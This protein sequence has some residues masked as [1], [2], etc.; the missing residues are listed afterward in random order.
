MTRGYAVIVGI[1]SY[2]GG[3][4]LEQ[5]VADATAMSNILSA[6]PYDFDVHLL[7]DEDAT[8]GSIKRKI[9]ACPPD[10]SLL[11]VYFS[12]HGYVN[13]M[14]TYFV[15]VDAEPLEEGIEVFEFTRLLERVG[16]SGVTTLTLIDSCHSGAFEPSDPGGRPLQVNDLERYLAQPPTPRAVIAACRPQEYSYESSE[17]YSEF[18]EHLLTGLHGYAADREGRITSSSLFDYASTPFAL[19]T[20]QRPMYRADLVDQIVLAEGFEPL[21][22]DPADQDVIALRTEEARRYADGF[23][24]RP[25]MSQDAWLGH[26]YREATQALS[27]ILRWFQTTVKQHPELRL[28]DDFNHAYRAILGHLANMGTVDVG[29][30][31]DLGILTQRL[32]AGAFGTVWKVESES[33]RAYKIYHPQ[34]LRMDD[35]LERFFCGYRAMQQLDHPRIVKVYDYTSCPVGFTMQYIDG[36]NLRELAPRDTLTPSQMLEVLATVSEVL[37]FAHYSASNPEGRVV[38]RDIKPENI[39]C[40]YDAATEE[41]RPHLTDFDLAWFATATALTKTAMGN[42][43]YAA[44]EQLARPNSAAARDPAVDAYSFAQLMYFC[45]VGDDPVS[46][47]ADRNSS[48]FTA[49]AEQRFSEGAAGRVVALYKSCT[50]IVPAERPDLRHISAEI[51]RSLQ[52][53]R[54]LQTTEL[55]VNRFLH[56]LA[57]ALVGLEIDDMGPQAVGFASLSGRT[58]VELSAPNPFAEQG[59]Q[60]EIQAKL[61]GQGGFMLEDTSVEAARRVLNRQID[62]ALRPSDGATRRGGGGRLYSATID[63]HSVVRNVEGIERVRDILSRVIEAAERT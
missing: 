50:N 32:G 5:A 47:E 33:I 31:T 59:E 30:G 36:S 39:I 44:P 9:A 55:S 37:K 3:N 60:I 17:T 56:E 40:S 51:A 11:L 34:D 24:S 21:T 52:D 62:N 6:D 38:H 45:L 1:N 8:R 49:E 23:R 16:R 27:P 46:L 18:T 20:Q 43:Y 10:A 12:G 15:T 19:S 29:T 2:P 26:G 14:G 53:L 42:P 61:R 48:K 7:L 58:H 28:H 57:F 35:K 22:H 25:G 63:I 54:T 13:D 41:W 4:E